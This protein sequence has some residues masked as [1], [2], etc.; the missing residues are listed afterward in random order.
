MIEKGIRLFDQE[1]SNRLLIFIKIEDSSARTRNLQK[2]R[3][4]KKSEK[5][6]SKNQKFYIIL[7]FLSS[8]LNRSIFKILF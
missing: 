2:L 6:H 4:F 8:F 5:L 3:S 1:F 7:T